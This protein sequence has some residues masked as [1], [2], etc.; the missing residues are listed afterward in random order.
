[1]AWHDL[2]WSVAGVVAGKVGLGGVVAAVDRG[3]LLLLVPLAFPL[4][5]RRIAPPAVPGPDGAV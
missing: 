2:S 4:F 1:M 3:L 5:H